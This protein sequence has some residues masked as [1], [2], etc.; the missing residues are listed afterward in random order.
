MKDWLYEAGKDK[1]EWGDFDRAVVLKALR[2][3][4]GKKYLLGA[5]WG[6][7]EKDPQGPIDCS[8]LARWAFAQSSVLLPHGSCEQI[9]CCEPWPF[10]NR[11]PEPLCLGF[12]DMHPPTGAVDHVN[13][14]LDDENVIEARADYGAVITRTRAKWEHQ[15]G[16]KGW[17]RIRGTII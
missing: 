1:F 17:Y 12:A 13:I 14:I 16:F 5:K 8:G 7:S 11:K 10:R 9:K 4:I 3:A 15:L 6:E 2:G